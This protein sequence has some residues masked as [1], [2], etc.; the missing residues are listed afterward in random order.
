MSTKGKKKNIIVRI[1]SNIY[2]KTFI[3]MAV[4]GAVLIALTLFGLNI[5]T[6]HGESVEVPSVLGMQVEEAA[7]VLAQKEL[8]YEV[9]DSIFLTGGVPGGITDQIPEEGSRVKKNRTIFLTMQ[10]KS[11]EKVTI[12]ALIDFSQRQAVAT[13]NSLG[14]TNIQIIEVPSAYRGLVLDVTYKGNSIGPNV[15][16]PKGDP[17]GLTVGAGGEAI[18]D[19]LIDILPGTVSHS[20]DAQRQDQPAID[21]SFY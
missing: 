2:A 5:Y 4:I 3:A 19:S 8:R 17:I 7:G 1:L 18:I 10:A 16:L 11:V 15:K 12:P 6:K 21:N 9:V 13:L 14:F 20:N